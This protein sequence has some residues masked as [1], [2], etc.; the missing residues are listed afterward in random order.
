MAKPKPSGLDVYARPYIPQALKSVN[1][2]VAHS[3]HSQLVRW[4]DFGQYT[5]SFAGSRFLP[6]DAPQ[7]S[8]HADQSELA[9]RLA[10]PLGPKRYYSHFSDALVQ[11]VQHLQHECEEH[12][13]YKVT[14]FQAPSD[15]RPAMFWLH[16]PGL[17]EMSLRVEIGDTVHLW[18]I[19]FGLRGEI[20][21]APLLT[22]RQDRPVLLS[23]YINLQY[24]SVIWGID[25]LKERLT[26]R[27]DGLQP[28]SMVFN[29]SFTI[30]GARLGALYK[31]VA[32][33]DHL[34]ATNQASQWMTSMLF[35]DSNSGVMQTTLNKGTI[36]WEPHDS[37]LNYEQIRAIDNVLNRAYGTL[38]YMISGPPG[39]GKTKTLVELAMQLISAVPEA[40]LLV[41]APSDPAADTITS[42]L[43]QHMTPKQLLRLNSPSRSFPEV[44]MSI[45]P[46]CHVD[47]DMFSLPPFPQMMAYKIVVTSCRDAEI[48][49]RARLR[50]ADLFSLEFGLLS[51]MHPEKTTTYPSLHWTGLLMDEAAQ[52]IEP[53][54][55]LG[56][57]VVAPP[58]KCMAPQQAPPI[59][60]MAGDQ[61]QLGPRTASKGTALQ[62]SLFERLLSRSVYSEHPLAR[63]R[64]SGGV[65]RPLTQKMLPILRPPFANLI[66]NYRSHPAILATP[67]ALFY[68]DT[69]EP[70][71]TNTDSL[72][73]W[74]GWKGERWPVLFAT[75]T[76]HDE[77]EQD[78]GGWYNNTEARMACE[79]AHS[80]LEAGLLE[81][82]EIC[83]ISPFR[84][85]VNL[86]RK[87]ARNKRNKIAMGEVSIGPLEAFQGL[88][89]RLVIFCTTRT[90]D[91][92]LE[93]DAARGLGVINE[94]R[95]YNVAMTRAKEGLVVIGNPAVLE[96]D[97]CW[98]AF[99]EFCQRNRLW[100]SG[101]GPWTPPGG[102]QG[103]AGRLEK[104]L[105]HAK[106]AA[107][108]QANGLRNGVRAL[109]QPDD[110]EH[111]LWQSG[112]DVESALREVDDAEAGGDEEA[113]SAP[114]AE[115][116]DG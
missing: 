30:Q 110:D 63:S 46:F 48:L 60:V 18:Q 65:M 112:V 40:H 23:P 86:L 51:A 59:F 32:D 20:L 116:D 89:S 33:V 84:A 38:P 4:I 106:G 34:L 85:H 45:L 114:E 109:G 78:G 102:E 107:D 19:H 7:P 67:S 104:Q 73:S 103:R 29:A 76:S 94:P 54:A 68:N 47:D 97:P 87:N 3:V 2:L 26:V 71:A 49:V 39:T 13:L 41:C 17:R 95:R 69:L 25:R 6:A 100:E 108:R 44:P 83:I 27:V 81:A 113:E 92:F 91:R 16:V 53:E 50:N 111:V 70:E 99:L 37:E 79:Y 96:K 55:C 77:T 62:T 8:T 9:D 28:T 57:T 5:H 61:N 24:H 115:D 36:A 15:P 21:E 1:Q 75:N 52:A 66:R 10:K 72:L 14:L 43:R 80:F 93:Q 22:Y 35:P 88:E 12:A 74:Q 98:Q 42:R 31:A 105:L 90:R 82:R 101:D 56:M 64:L 58:E 11:E